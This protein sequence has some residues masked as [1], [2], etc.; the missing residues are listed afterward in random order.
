MSGYLPSCLGLVAPYFNIGLVIICV[1]LFL[2]L[3]S[4]KNSKM[5]LAPWKFLFYAV[6]IYIFEEILTILTNLNVLS[7]PAVIFPMFEMVIIVLFIYMLLIQKE[8]LS[9]GKRKNG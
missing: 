4:I 5:F 8:H 2:E 1:I 6:L 7:L 3:F 9:K